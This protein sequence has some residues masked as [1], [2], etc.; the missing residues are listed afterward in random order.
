VDLIVQPEHR[1][2]AVPTSLDALVRDGVLDAELA[3][4]VSVLVEARVPVIVAGAVDAA[5]RE[6]ILE[7]VLAALPADADRVELAG[8][9]EDFAWL[10]EA[11][12]L[13]WRH[14][15]PTPGRDRREPA[16]PDRTVILA[17]DLA[18]MDLAATWSGIVRI[19]VRA[20]SLG[21]G[22]AATMQA[23][24]LEAVLDRLGNAPFRLT[25]DERSRLGLV[26]VLEGRDGS[27]GPRVSAAH[28]LRPVARDQHGHVQALGPAVLATWNETG[29]AF[30]HF[31][32][33]VIPELALRTGRRAGDFE[34]DLDTRREAFERGA[35]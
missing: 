13:G 19:A 29:G 21:Y 1:G 15:G 4:L 27:G 33:G 11:E 20:V 28:Y 2:H 31:G 34:I 9:T 7:A 14:D 6:R 10:P 18:P 12:S 17:A 35:A 5:S 8:P 22:L 26:L 25:A 32:W 3:A 24:S 23:G 30:D 16:T